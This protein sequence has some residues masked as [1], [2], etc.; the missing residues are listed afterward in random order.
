MAV[1]RKGPSKPIPSGKI[2]P[3]P[4][5]PDY[6]I[7]KFHKVVEYPYEV[8]VDKNIPITPNRGGRGGTKYPFRKLEVGDSF[9]VPKK[10]GGM[11]KAAHSV[12][13]KIATRMVEEKGVRGVRIWRIK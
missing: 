12:G 10:S 8:K 9:F 6:K 13:I 5:S 3:G 11:H 7:P 4:A 1:T 2:I